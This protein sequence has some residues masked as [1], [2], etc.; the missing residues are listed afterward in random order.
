M[1]DAVA[2]INIL[3]IKPEHR[4]H[5]GSR[6]THRFISFKMSKDIC[7]IK[8][9]YIPDNPGVALLVWFPTDRYDELALPSGKMVP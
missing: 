3:P 7:C 8:K 6:T 2:R 5:M 1:H 4:P 9:N